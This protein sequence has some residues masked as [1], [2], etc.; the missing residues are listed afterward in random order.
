MKWYYYPIFAIALFLSCNITQAQVV[1]SEIYFDPIGTDDEREWIKLYNTS[2]SP[3]DISNYSI[4]WGTDDYGCG[5]HY[6]IPNGTTIGGNDYL[7]IGGPNTVLIPSP[8]CY[9]LEHDFEGDL[10]NETFPNRVGPAVGI[11]LFDRPPLPFSPFC[12]DYDTD[13]IHQVVYNGTS[14][15]DGMVDENGNPSVVHVVNAPEGSSLLYD[16]TTD[17]WS[18]NTNFVFDTDC[19]GC[20]P[21]DVAALIALYNSTDGANWTDNTGWTD[22]AAGL[23]CDVCNWFGVICN[24]LGE[25]AKINLNNNSLNGTIPSELGDI[26][27]LVELFL[28]NNS[29][30]GN[31]PSEIGNLQF[32]D[33][34]WLSDNQL[35][36]SIPSEIGSL[37]F[38][39]N[40]LLRNNQLT[41][42]IPTTFGDLDELINLDLGTNNLNGSIPSELGDLDKLEQL[43]IHANDLSGVIPPELGNLQ[44][45]ERL[46]LIGNQLTGSIP[47]ELGNLSN[48]QLLY[49]IDNQL[50][51]E[52]PKELAQLTNL[53]QLRVAQNNLSGCYPFEFI[54]LCSQL[55]NT[56]TNQFISDGNSFDAD[57]EDFCNTSAGVCICHPDILALEDLYNNTGGPAWSDK[58]GWL[59]NCDPC[60]DINGNSPWDGITCV[61]NRVTE[62]DL[63]FNNLL[64]VIPP[65]IG[66]LGELQYLALSNNDLMGSIPTSIG[67]LTKLERLYLQKNDLIGSIP[68]EIGNLVNLLT[69]DLSSND[70]TG[71]IPTTI[72]N[73]AVLE[74][75]FLQL[76]DLTGFIP[77]SIDGLSSLKELDLGANDLTGFI[78]ASIGQ[79]NN[80]ELFKIINNDLSGSIP[81]EMGNMSNLSAFLA[82]G[83]NFSGTLPRELSKL[84][85]LTALWLY[86]NSNLTTPIPLELCVLCSQLGTNSTNFL[87][88]NGTSMTTPWEDF[89]SNTTCAPLDIKVFLQGAMTGSNEMNTAFG[90]MLP[91]SSPYTQASSIGYTLPTPIPNDFVDWVWIGLERAELNGSFIRMRTKAAI[92][93]KDGTIVMPNEEPVIFANFPL[94]RPYHISVHHRNHLGI[95]TASPVID[96]SGN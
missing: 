3:V 53:I 63:N 21:A 95:M 44:N 74:Y 2:A 94:G 84:R 37:S 77:S 15:S 65:S 38:L 5:G 34:L 88:S 54:P 59:S 13:P 19:S 36:G 52:L 58:A 41:G 28:G 45:L 81:P 66:N 39:K 1:L 23:D 55:D 56:N 91:A 62:L 46:S 17:T 18:T 29:L 42:H 83:N 90:N 25:I 10:T 80:L 27:S 76:N 70:L 31:I 51:G 30:T 32:L 71:S 72:G 78:P 82:N 20:I 11:A 60:G 26:T 87:I 12:A 24:T 61:N 22:G 49:L 43:L 64:G 57:W 4:A 14:N 35:T 93:K 16:P 47:P 85:Q 8:D 40:L 50:S 69:L 79:L 92:V 48:L 7:I 75:L 86:G 6:V 67:Q 9:D 96:A 89:C 73:L 33:I 68:S